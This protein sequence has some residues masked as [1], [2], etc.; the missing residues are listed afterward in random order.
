MAGSSMEV[1]AQPV[2]AKKPVIDSGLFGSADLWEWYRESRGCSRDTYPESYI[3]KYTSIRRLVQTLT[4]QNGSIAKPKSK[5]E[6]SRWR[7]P[8]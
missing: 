1:A 7:D 6:S 3:T 5:V 8:D 4:K 2:F